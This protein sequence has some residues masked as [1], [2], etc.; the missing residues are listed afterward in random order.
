MQHRTRAL[1][2][3]V[4]LLTAG[5]SAARAAELLMFERADCPVCAR[6]H[7]E[8]GSIYPR[9]AEARRAPLRRVV[10]G[11]DPGVT[12]SQPVRYTP[13]FVLAEN[14]QER[15]RIT[16]YRNDETFWGLLGM[17]LSGRDTE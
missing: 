7:R 13:T 5:G 16:G 6:W 8:I 3:S 14:G 17:L 15:G 4:L 10:L 9:T 2:L 11:H 1:L 12:L